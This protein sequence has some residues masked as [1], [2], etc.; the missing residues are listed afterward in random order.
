MGRYPQSLFEMLQNETEPEEK[1]GLADTD[2]SGR[3]VLVTGSTSGLGREAALA[4]GRLGAHVIAHGRREQAGRDVVAEIEASGS[5]AEFMAADFADVDAVDG[6]VENVRTSVDELD[7][8][9]NNAG[10]LFRDAGTTDLGVEMTF[11]VNHLSPYQLTTGLLDTLAEDARVV[12][13]ASIGH[14]GATLNIDRVAELTGFSPWA[15]YCRSKLANI[16]FANELARRLEASGSDVTSNSFHPGLI[17]G[18]EFSRSFVAPTRGV[19]DFLKTLPVG[20]T[21]KDGA[22]TMVYLGTSAGVADVTGSYFARCRQRRAAPAARDED[23]MCELW[24][25][26]A[27]LLGIEEPLVAYR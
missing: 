11:H 1:A 9:C 21:P 23:A 19:T 25:R 7:I 15:A 26:S 5:S 18:S 2:L 10:G 14:R 12:T 8:L 22:A 17:P 20:D 6:L 16:Q 4:F 24:E 27:D 13:T 3:T